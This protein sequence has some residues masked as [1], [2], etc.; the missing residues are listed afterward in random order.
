MLTDA[1]YGPVLLL[2]LSTRPFG[3]VPGQSGYFVAITSKCDCLFT[4][5]FIFCEFRASRRFCFIMYLDSAPMLTKQM[6]CPMTCSAPS[7]RNTQITTQHHLH[8][9]FV[10]MP[11]GFRN[12]HKYSSE[13]KVLWFV[14]TLAC[15]SGLLH[16]QQSTQIPISTIKWSIIAT[17]ERA[18][19]ISVYR[20]TG[21]II[22]GVHGPRFKLIPMW[23]LLTLY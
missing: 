11:H 5:H 3:N 22:S 23:S 6:P 4:T 7:F 15:L 12:L 14:V 13:P 10:F 16:P 2:F 18:I 20:G 9:P 17:L 19:V 21:N 8:L 1:V